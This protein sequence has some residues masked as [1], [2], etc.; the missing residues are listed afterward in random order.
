MFLQYSTRTAPPQQQLHT[1]AS[2]YA[3]PGRSPTLNMIRELL[4]VR[5]QVTALVVGTFLFTT[6]VGFWADVAFGLTHWEA[7]QA[8]FAEGALPAFLTLMLAWAGWH[9]WRFLRPADAGRRRP[10]SESIARVQRRIQRF[11]RD[12]WGMFLIYA[13]CGP[14][15]FRLVLRDRP[16]LYNAR[17]FGLMVLLQLSVAILAAL[18]TYLLLLERLGRLEASLGFARVHHGL[19]FRLLMVASFVPLLGYSLL[20]E[21]SW[22]R[23]GHLSGEMA[24][25]WAALALVTVVVA[26]LSLRALANSLRPV[27]LVLGRSGA[28]GHEELAQLQAQSSDEIG[29]LT[30]TLSRLFR[31]LAD[32]ES[33][34]HAVV[35]NAAEGVIVVDQHGAIDTFNLAAEQLFGFSAQEVRGRPLSWLLPSL[36]D[37]DGTPQATAEE[38][39]TEGL[40]RSGQRIPMSVRVSEFRISDRRMFTCLVAD[41]SARKAAQE[42][43][44]K[45]EARYRD[46]V[47]TAHDLVWSMDTEGRW[48]YLNGAAQSIYGLDPGDMLGRPVADFRAPECADQEAA[49]FAEVL[50]GRELYQF[51]T[52]HLDRDGGRRHLSFNARVQLDADGE[53]RRITGTARD[54]SDQKAYQRQLSYQAEHDMLTG[55]YNRRYFQQE[56]ERVAARV[57]RSG[58]TCGLLYIDLDQFKYINDTLGHAAGDRLLVE[59]SRMLSEHVREGEL[60]ARFGGDEFTVLLYNVEHDNLRCAADNF[61]RL[62]ESYRFFDDGKSFN[63]SCSIGA[64]LVDAATHSADEAL[65]HA[66]LACN[67]AKS[68]GRNRV[69]LYNPAERDQDGMAE[70]MGWAARVR[71]MLEHDRFAMMFQP[72]VSVANGGIHDY[73]VL[74]RMPCDDG[75]MIL[76]GGFLPAA[77]RFGLIHAVDRWMVSRAMERLAEL[78]AQGVQARFSINLSGHAFTDP[79]LLELIRERLAGTGLEPALLTFE[80]T[81]TAAITNLS[82]AV[83]F[84]GALKDIGCQFSLDDFGSGFCSFTYL[85]HLPVDKLKID[86]AFV[87]NIATSP[88]DQAMVRSM[89][90]V[91]HA[92]GKLTIA[93][94][95]EDAEAL[96]LLRE[97]GVD[98]AQGH[99]LGEPQ[100]EP[101]TAESLPPE[102]TVVSPGH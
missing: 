86:G 100:S 28:A 2:L 79:T 92:L 45:A 14:A 18:P 33:H 8:A 9:F 44:R 15:I 16:D 38:Q 80:I 78:R 10:T 32:Q 21:H 34:M 56:L 42:E 51:E 29:Y 17:D 43:Q 31:R 66:D 22:L 19:R 54:I 64:A 75:Q 30:H 87:Q 72:I 20:V 11:S 94:C 81:E 89:T 95:V 6:M 7:L 47:E 48:S 40:Y 23:N 71:E 13:L 49:A 52:V 73:E 36:V 76:P 68:G 59:I 12:Y 35:G 61:R 50:Q 24:A 90:Q 58:A 85:K 93:E 99:F 101:A 84:I 4:S 26:G 102:A 25:L 46:L 63:I 62:F 60:L 53:P 70:D 83:E 27:Q 65:A 91:A 88:V 1:A 57:T 67:L 82:A 77:E 41:I 39:E 55:L 5:R 97:F 96:R 37:S 69:N 3:L 74:M 98:Y